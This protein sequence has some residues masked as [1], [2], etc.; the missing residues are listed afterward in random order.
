MAMKRTNFYFPV[1]M[2]ARMKKAAKAKGIAVSEILRAAVESYLE[3][4]GI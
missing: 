4:M 1:P 3:R 2:I